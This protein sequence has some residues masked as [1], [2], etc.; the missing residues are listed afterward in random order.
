V[1]GVVET[2]PVSVCPSCLLDWVPE[3]APACR[4][5]A[6]LGIH[7]TVDLHLHR[8]ELALPDGTF[9]TPVSFYRGDPYGRDKTPD[10]GLYLDHRWRPAWTHRHLDWP[11]FGVPSEEAETHRALSD[12]LERARSGQRVELGCWGGHGRTGTALAVV[13]A[14]SGYPADDAVSWVR[15]NYCERAVETPAQADFVLIL[16]RA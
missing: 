5:A 10:Y 1:P 12:L 4:E 9:I 7:R 11:D 14:L 16:A 6:H 2:R 8:S 15:A 3:T 13:V